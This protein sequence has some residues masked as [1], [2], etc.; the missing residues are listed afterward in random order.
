MKLTYTHTNT[1]IHTN[2]HNPY[3]IT[4]ESMTGEVHLNKSELH[5]LTVQWAGVG[6]G[7]ST[8]S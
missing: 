5:K 4:M 6:W 7:P 3:T 8:D 2:T 1:H